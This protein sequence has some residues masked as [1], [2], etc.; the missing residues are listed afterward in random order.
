L[1][2]HSGT[3][4]RDSKIPQPYPKP[5]DSKGNI[6]RK[7]CSNR[8]QQDVEQKGKGIQPKSIDESAPITVDSKLQ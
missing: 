4:D 7:H 6:V 5:K 8:S 1:A 3:D 2:K